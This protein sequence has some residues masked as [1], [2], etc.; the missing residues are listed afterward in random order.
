M[1]DIKPHDV[2]LKWYRGESITDEELVAGLS[3]FD[4]LQSILSKSGPPFDI[5][6]DRAVKVYRG[7]KSIWEARNEKP[8]GWFDTLS[9][10]E[11]A[12]IESWPDW[13]KEPSQLVNKK[14]K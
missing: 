14:D 4:Q 1:T 11:K 10:G 12:R 7:L 13:K 8:L 9:E 6:L 2:Y 5:A 3:H